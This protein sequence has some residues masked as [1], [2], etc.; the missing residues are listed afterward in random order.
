MESNQSNNN[1]LV[2]FGTISIAVIMWYVVVKRENFSLR[3]SF[4]DLKQK[5]TESYTSVVDGLVDG[6]RSSEYVTNNSQ[7][8]ETMQHTD[9]LTGNAK[10]TEINLN[11][12]PDTQLPPSSVNVTPYDVDV[13]DPS[14][15]SFQVS[16]PRVN[17]IT[18]A[19]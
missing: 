13:A 11:K 14:S 17:S 12:H 6:K 3:Q 16:A 5:L 18:N 10:L 1:F 8:F 2:V 9:Q 7:P 15:Y 19:I 4:S